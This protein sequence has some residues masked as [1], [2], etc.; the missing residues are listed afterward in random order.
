MWTYRALPFVISA[1]IFVLP[2]PSMTIHIGKLLS[3]LTMLAINARWGEPRIRYAFLMFVVV[4]VGGLIP[5][6]HLWNPMVVPAIVFAV[7]AWV[8]P[9]LLGSE[10]WLVRGNTSKAT[11]VLSLITIP[12]AAAALVVWAYLT[13]PDLSVYANMIPGT[14]IGAV[15]GAAIVFAVFNALAEEVVFR[16]VVWQALLEC[17]LATRWVL[18]I[19]AL[20]FGVFH[21]GGVPSGVAG[22]ALAALYGLALGGVRLLSKGLLMPVIVHAF[23]DL[24]IFLIVMRLAGR[25]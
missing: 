9:R 14:G 13:Q 21:F 5:A 18:I 10:S 23:A 17:G 12:L 15:V 19:Q 11:L 22:M 7:I 2:A 4:M 25:W 8:R 3:I 20:V 1:S 16:G 24:T 6:L